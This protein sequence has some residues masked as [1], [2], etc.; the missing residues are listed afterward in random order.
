[1]NISLTQLVQLFQANLAG[2][3][4][5]LAISPAAIWF[6]RRGHLLDIPGREAHKQ[7]TQ[8]TPMAGGIVLVA[9]AILLMTIFRLWHR[10]YFLVFLAASIVFLFGLWDDSKC[11]SAPIK[12]AGQVLASILVILSG[13]SVQILNGFQIHFLGPTL[14]SILQ[15]GITVFWL[16]GITNAV[17]MIDSFDGL[18]AGITGIAFAFFMG[19]AL[20]AKQGDLA[21]FSAI[22][23]GICIGLFLFNSH[24]AR[25]FLGDSGAQTLGFI[26]AVVAILYMPGKLPQG[27]SWFVPIMVL[28]MPIF[29]MVLVVVSRIRRRTSVFR[30]DCCHTYHRLVGM[31][32]DTNRAVL[33]LH[34]AAL[35]LNLLAFIALTLKPV[36]ATAVFGLTLLIGILFLVYLEFVHPIPR[37]AS[38]EVVK[39]GM[40]YNEKT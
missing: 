19:M 7:H 15:W 27:S 31:G 11:L 4:V 5:T 38:S 13:V 21:I 37:T 16:T 2:I 33:I 26:L 1:M 17:N 6:A 24:P 18:A 32:F 39:K 28:G 34:L 35:M 25:L 8:P 12:F 30:G 3:V 23:L 20:V 29:D 36:E 22:F 14:I 9:A 10:P 40:G